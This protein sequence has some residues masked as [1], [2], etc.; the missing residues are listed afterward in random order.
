MKS[1][2][3]SRNDHSSHINQTIVESLF[4]IFNGENSGRIEIDQFRS[5]FASWIETIYEFV[6]EIVGLAEDFVF[7]NF[8]S[9]V[10]SAIQESQDFPRDF[11]GNIII[12]DILV[13]VHA[14]APDQGPAMPSFDD[15]PWIRPKIRSAYLMLSALQL[16]LN[17]MDSDE[18]SEH[19]FT[20][21]LTP[22]VRDILESFLS[23]SPETKKEIFEDLIN[24]FRSVHKIDLPHDLLDD[25][26]CSPVNGLRKFLSD[27]GL[28]LVLKSLY[29]LLDVDDSNC[30][31]SSQLAG[32]TQ[33]FLEVHTPRH[34]SVFFFD[35]RSVGIV[36]C[37]NLPSIEGSVLHA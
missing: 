24:T 5:F 13:Q 6:G 30:L 25:L 33:L 32:V 28:N 17:S 34:L 3:D 35:I 1:T 26:I 15:A 8:I 9:E 27:G 2:A 4:R 7:E 22:V 19:E 10:V 20:N 16:Q 18:L 11:A 36:G 37:T 31:S 14:D 12:N 23:L 29:A 21:I